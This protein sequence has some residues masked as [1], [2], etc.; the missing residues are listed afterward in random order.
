MILYMIPPTCFMSLLP[1]DTLMSST[2][3]IPISAKLPS[4]FNWIRM[5]VILI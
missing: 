4:V 3:K 2:F 5:M 1:M